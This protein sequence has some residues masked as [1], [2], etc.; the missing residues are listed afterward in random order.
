ML[1]DQLKVMA[2]QRSETDIKDR[3]SLEAPLGIFM[4]TEH[5]R[6]LRVQ[7]LRECILSF[8]DENPGCGL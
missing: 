1:F 5:S 2:I 7:F 3:G 6:K 8:C 4:P